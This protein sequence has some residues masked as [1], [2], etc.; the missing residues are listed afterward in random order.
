MRIWIVGFWRSVE[1]GQRGIWELVG[2]FSTEAKAVEQCRDR[3]FWYYEWTLD[4]VAPSE[5]Q[6]PPGGIRI[7][8]MTEP[9]E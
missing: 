7:P 1:N 3:R 6:C 9:A 5:K 4:T 2:V 8:N